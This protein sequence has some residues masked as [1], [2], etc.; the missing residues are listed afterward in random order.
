MRTSPNGLFFASEIKS[1]RA[2]GIPLPTDPE[3]LKLYFLLGYVPD[4]YSAYQT[5]RKLEPGSW[6]LYRADGSVTRGR[7]WNLPA[8]ECPRAARLLA[9]GHLS[10]PPP[11]F[12]RS[13][14]AALDSGRAAGRVS[15]RRHRFQPGSGVHGAPV[16]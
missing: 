2:A 14:A 12:R 5:V 8:P 3:A 10:T 7:Y 16:A 13:G 6:L 11:D 15:E 1:L 4:P 9:R